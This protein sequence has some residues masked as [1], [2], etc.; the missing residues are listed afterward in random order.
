[1]SFTGCRLEGGE[2]VCQK[3]GEANSC[4]FIGAV[5]NESVITGKFTRPSYHPPLFYH[6]ENPDF[7]RSVTLKHLSTSNNAV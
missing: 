2:T 6:I 3:D 7:T 1:M 5:E 4:L